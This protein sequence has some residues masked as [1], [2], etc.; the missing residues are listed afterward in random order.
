MGIVGKT[1]LFRRKI[2]FHPEEPCLDASGEE[3]IL[4]PVLPCGVTRGGHAVV[5]WLFIFSPRIIHHAC[6]ACPECVKGSKRQR[7]EGWSR[8]DAVLRWIGL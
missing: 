6:P 8:A 2:N 7:V 3:K 1:W 5:S 4:Y